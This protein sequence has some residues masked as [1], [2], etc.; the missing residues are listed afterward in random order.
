[1]LDPPDLTPFTTNRRP[2]PVQLVAEEIGLIVPEEV[3]RECDHRLAVAQERDEAAE[4][5]AGD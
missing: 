2:V 4:E 1:M 3:P 5:F